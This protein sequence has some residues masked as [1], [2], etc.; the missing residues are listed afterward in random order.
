MGFVVLRG[1]RLEDGGNDSCANAEAASAA[2]APQSRDHAP[3]V[4][5]EPVRGLAPFLGGGKAGSRLVG[6]A[7]LLQW[8]SLLLVF[9]FSSFQ[10]VA[11]SAL[12]LDE[13]DG[14]CQSCLL[15]KS[16]LFRATANSYPSLES[17]TPANLPST[18]KSNPISWRAR[19]DLGGMKILVPSPGVGLRA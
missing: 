7:E 12:V 14:L 5:T 13:S 18:N 11:G 4:G 2:H 3:G 17:L 15:R 19:T 16:F 1:I 10:K 9:R 8:L 6:F